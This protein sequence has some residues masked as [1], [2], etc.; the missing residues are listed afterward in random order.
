MYLQPLFTD[1]ILADLI[2][3]QSIPSSRLSIKYWM[4]LLSS[5]VT[6]QF[7][8]CI[9]QWAIGNCSQTADSN[10]ICVRT[11]AKAFITCGCHLGPCQEPQVCGICCFFLIH[12]VSSTGEQN[13][14]ASACFVPE[15]FMETHLPVSFCTLRKHSD[16]SAVLLFLGVKSFDILL[17]L[18]DL[19]TAPSVWKCENFVDSWEGNRSKPLTGRNAVPNVKF[20]W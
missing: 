2:N 6:I 14:M 7:V 19:W 18:F 9:S 1:L 12:K 4:D 5:W 20:L 8:L 13:W 16:Y 17:V 3:T 15:G 10:Q 11:P